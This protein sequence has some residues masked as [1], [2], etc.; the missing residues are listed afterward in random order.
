MCG[1]PWPP[2]CDYHS[3]PMAGSGR[4]CPTGTACWGQGRITVGSGFLIPCPCLML[5]LSASVDA[6]DSLIKLLHTGISGS[7]EQASFCENSL[8]LQEKHK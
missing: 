1:R 5:T 4:W 3:P 8:K 7:P 6:G 2:L